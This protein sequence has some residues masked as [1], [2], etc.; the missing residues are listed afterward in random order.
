[1][2]VRNNIICFYFSDFL[3]IL[4]LRDILLDGGIEKESPVCKLVGD[5]LVEAA[6]K[7]KSHC[8][9]SPENVPLPAISN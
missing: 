8:D 9:W 5:R 6:M 2:H 7:C 1:M 4:A 3:Q